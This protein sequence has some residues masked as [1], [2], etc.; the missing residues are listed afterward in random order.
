MNKRLEIFISILIIVF[1]LVCFYV[2]YLRKEI[3]RLE[4]DN[5]ELAERI[6]SLELDNG[7][8]KIALKDC[9]SIIKSAEEDRAI[10][11]LV[12]NYNKKEMKKMTNYIEFMQSLCDANNLVYPYYVMEE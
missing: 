1:I 9:N 11:M 6:I 3:S 10:E 4:K 7:I 12:I 5:I 8:M 2:G